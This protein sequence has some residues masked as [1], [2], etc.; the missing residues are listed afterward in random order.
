[1]KVVRWIQCLFAIAAVYDGLL[2]A[3]FLLSPVRVFA[4]S[5]VTPPNH[6]GYVQFPGALL[7]IFALMFLA[8]ARDPRGNRNIIPYGICLKIAYCGIVFYY[9]VTSGI[10]GMWKPFALID[11]MMML[12]FL[13]SFVVLRRLKSVSTQV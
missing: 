4:V 8:V 10:P 13:W 11:A 6:W 3:A 12:A 5:G 9:W 1:M 7:L 2:G